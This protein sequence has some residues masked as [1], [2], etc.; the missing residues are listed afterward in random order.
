MNAIGMMLVGSI[1]HATLFAIA[2]IAAYLAL[3]HRGPAAG[4]LAAMTGLA[5]MAVVSIVTLSPW[6]RWWIV[7]QVRSRRR[8]GRD[9]RVMPRRAAV[10]KGP[11]DQDPARSGPAP[12]ADRSVRDRHA[13]CPRCSA[14][15][16]NCRARRCVATRDG[17]AGANGWRRG[18][19]PAS[20]WA[21]AR[22]G[23]GLRGVASLRARSRPV[24]DREIEELVGI[25]GAELG[26]TRR[27][28]LREATELTTPAT[29]GWRRPVVLL[30]FN[31]RDWDDDERRAV[32][33][34]ELAHV[35]RGDFAAGLVAQARRGAALL[36][37]PGA[38]AGG[39][40]AAGTGA[41]R[42][43][44]GRPALGRPVVVPRHTGADGPAPRRSATHLVGP[45]LPP[46]TWHL[47]AEDPDAEERTDPSATSRCRRR[48]A[49]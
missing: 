17:G 13:P 39:A 33:A 11:T 29:I 22:L 10:A 34:H 27:V 43:R 7:R 21:S 23:L 35:R 40:A 48:R 6:P 9:S 5:V 16:K 4:S 42:R 25:L 26:C 36:S 47:R 45:G 49:A 28:A 30:P 31:W 3:R 19:S 15:S 8:G 37:S 24:A 32:L 14:S 12:A 2:G 41:R 46:F 18:S 20:R 44:L 1:A 38:L